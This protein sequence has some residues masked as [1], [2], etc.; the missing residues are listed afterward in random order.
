MAGKTGNFDAL[1]V[2]FC[3]RNDVGIEDFGD[4]SL[5]LLCDSMRLREIN[6]LARKLLVFADGG[7]TLHEIVLR[8][9]GDCGVPVQ[10]MLHSIAEAMLQM[11]RQGIVRRMVKLATE[12][13][14]DMGEIKYLVNPDVSF[15]PE[16]D[17]G[18]ILFNADSDSLEVINPTAAEI[19]SCLA[20]P[21]TQAQV[22]E[23]LCSVCDGASQGAVEKD[24]SEFLD[25]MVKK[26][27]IGMVEKP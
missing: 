2:R 22:V 25:S 17:D 18:A 10:E 12:R 8:A 4:R 16:D 9:A 3:L 11:E 13:T 15:R 1:T 26:G 14:E 23:H 19:W 27:F 20:A 7:R 5:V 24:V 21:C 6:A